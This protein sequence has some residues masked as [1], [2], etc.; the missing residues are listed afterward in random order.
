MCIRILLSSSDYE[1]MMLCFANLNKCRRKEI[2]LSTW[3]CLYKS[4]RFTHN[5]V[6][7]V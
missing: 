6:H 4:Y 3:S 2:A 5:M 1:W 7:C